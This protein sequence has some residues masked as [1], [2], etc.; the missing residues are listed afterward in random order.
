LGAIDNDI[1]CHHSKLW[2]ISSDNNE[3]KL[4]DIW[5]QLK[6]QRVPKG[7]LG[8]KSCAKFF[9]IGAGNDELLLEAS[10]N[11]KFDVELN[12]NGANFVA[13]N[14][15]P[16]TLKINFDRANEIVNG[17]FE[18]TSLYNI[19][20]PSPFLYDREFSDNSY[21]SGILSN[22]GLPVKRPQEGNMIGWLKPIPKKLFTISYES[23]DDL[24]RNF[25]E[26]FR[27]DPDFLAEDGVDQTQERNEGRWV[28]ILLFV[29]F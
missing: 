29:K 14:Y 13:R 24:Q 19:R 22:L 28:S 23:D 3:H 1:E 17:N 27:D 12:L 16:R 15:S 6:P 4:L 18:R 2:V 25:P 11:R 5:K 26:Y 10:L 8:D 20:R 9:T 7:Y 21:V